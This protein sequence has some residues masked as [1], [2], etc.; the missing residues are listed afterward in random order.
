MSFAKVSYA[1]IIRQFRLENDIKTWVGFEAQVRRVHSIPPTF[2]ILVSYKDEDGDNITIDTDAELADLLRQSNGRTIKFH[3]ALRDPDA[4]SFVVVGDQVQAMSVDE[5]EGSRAPSELDAETTGIYPSVPAPESVA[6]VEQ[7]PAPIEVDS[8][9]SITTDNDKAKTPATESDS[10]PDPSKTTPEGA[11]ASNTDNATNDD[12]NNNNNNNADPFSAFFGGIGPIFEE[13]QAEIARHP[14]FFER[15]GQLAGQ[16]RHHPIPPFALDT[17]PPPPPGLVNKPKPTSNPCSTTS[18]NSSKTN[19]STARVLT[20]ADT[21]PTITAASAVAAVSA[22]PGAAAT[23]TATT[24]VPPSLVLLAVP[25][26]GMAVP[27]LL[28]PASVLTTTL[29][30][31]TLTNPAGVASYAT[32]CHGRVAEIH[33]E[34]AHEFERREHPWAA[35]WEEGRRG[36]CGGRRGRGWGGC[37]R[38]GWGGWNAEAENNNNEERN[39]T[40]TEGQ[41]SSS[42]SIAAADAA[43]T[44]VQEPTEKQKEQRNEKQT[45]LKAMGFYDDAENDELLRRYNGNVER[46]V[47]VLLQ[48]AQQ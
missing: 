10:Q 20:I 37:G 36:R 9:A 31:P 23:T 8:V 28:A 4:A 45:Q 42:T 24:T 41:A 5:R 12:S 38:G 33:E 40:E 11:T 27:A 21:T 32:G 46:V 13:M 22:D 1:G 48:R 18:W 14:E 47:E 6:S 2:T 16:V 3:V 35:A 17:L 7:T 15:M 43:T 25:G 39:A 29:K 44:D 30:P 26:P 19:I 34:G